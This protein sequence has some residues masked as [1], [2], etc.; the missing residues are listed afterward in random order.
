MT[1][2]KIVSTNEIHLGYPKA[3]AC[4]VII[5]SVQFVV[6]KTTT[7]AKAKHMACQGFCKLSASYQQRGRKSP[8]LSPLLG[9]LKKVGSCAQAELF[10]KA[11]GEGGGGK[12]YSLAAQ[13]LVTQS[14]CIVTS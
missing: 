3:D 14:G 1:V 2:I 7:R 5:W 11:C 10:L 4:G 12:E 8:N 9:Q 13:V 6:A